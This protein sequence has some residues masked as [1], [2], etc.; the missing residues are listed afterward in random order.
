MKFNGPTFLAPKTMPER[1]YPTGVVVENQ[2]QVW[3]ISGWRGAREFV[4]IFLRALYRHLHVGNPQMFTIDEPR[5]G[6]SGILVC[7][8]NYVYHLLGH[9]WYGVCEF[10]CFTAY[11]F[12]TDLDSTWP[13]GNAMHTLPYNLPVSD[14]E[15]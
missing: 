8:R 1:Q 3:A 5:R 11:N 6:G 10:I 2:L 9:V 4:M 13:N 12:Y 7:F 15:E 14:D